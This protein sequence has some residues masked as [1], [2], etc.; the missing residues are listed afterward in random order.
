ML[1]S[2]VAARWRPA[3]EQL[4]FFNTGQE[5][6]RRELTAAI[7]RYG[8]M[9]VVDTA[10]QLTLRVQR[11][12]Q[13]QALFAIGADGRPIGCVVYCRIE[14]SRFLLLHLAVAEDHAAGGPGAQTM[15]L[16][17][18]IAAVRAIARRTRGVETVELLYGA[19]RTV[20]IR[21]R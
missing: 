12:P 4:L 10:G 13:S 18:L 2:Q 20:P 5:R 9:E 11:L 6:V 14:P 7:D 16:M 3:L 21:A 19:G 8:T 1:R 17:H 15:V